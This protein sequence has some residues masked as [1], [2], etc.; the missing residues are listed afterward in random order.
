[1]DAPAVKVPDNAGLQR[2]PGTA[3]K[4]STTFKLAT[5]YRTGALP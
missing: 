2:G 3:F 4:R 5:T 1:M